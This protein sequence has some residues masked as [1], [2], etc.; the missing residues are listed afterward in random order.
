MKYLFFSS[1]ALFIVAFVIQCAPPEE[2]DPEVL[3]GSGDLQNMT[4]PIYGGSAPDAPEHDAVV[5]L[6]Q[7]AKGGTAIYVLPFCSG[8]LIAP[9]VVLTAAHCLD[10]AK[11]GSA[12]KTMSPTAL[13]IYVGNNPSVDLLNHL[14][15]V[16]ETVIYPGYNRTAL[17]ND[18]ALIRLKNAITEPVAPVANLPVVEGFTSA[19][20]GS[21]I[22]FAGFGEIEDGTWGVKLQ[23]DGILGSLGCYVAGCPDGGDPATQ[24]G[25]SQAD[26]GPCFGDSGGPAFVYRS[27][28]VYVGG[29]TSYGD[30]GCTVYGVSTR[31]DAFESFIDNFVSPPPPPD[32]SADGFCNPACATGADPDCSVPPAC[33][34]GTCNVGES[35]D[36]RSGTI[37]CPADCPGKTSGKPNQRY[38][39]VNGV[40]EGPA[41]P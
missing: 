29:I 13:A 21:T 30:S 12:F 33:G 3:S 35:C 17:R 40:C 34:D 18:L 2:T 32:C 11:K 19:D 23:A 8:T 39:Y 15:Y 37:S 14:Y 7:F 4:Q 6:H 31:V 27:S 5:G 9:D 41:C 16:Q 24:I 38:C 28:N 26:S 20:I 22:N 10:T 25:Y 36:G 1:L